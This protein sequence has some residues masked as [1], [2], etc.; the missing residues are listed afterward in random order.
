MSHGDSRTMNTNTRTF[1]IS[2]GCALF[3]MFLIY[4]YSQE[5]KAQYD[6]RYGTTKT[7]LI[8]VKDIQEMQTIDETMITQE[9]RPVDFL[10][11]GAIESPDDAVGLVAGSPIKKGEQMLLSKLLS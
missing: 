2:M 8:A 4:S 6:K 9:E 1:W 5:Q 7:V 3:S 11:P 10:Q